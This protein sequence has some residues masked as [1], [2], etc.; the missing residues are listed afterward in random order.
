[1]LPRFSKESDRSGFSAVKKAEKNRAQWP[2]EL[3]R[4]V[5]RLGDVK[6]EPEGSGKAY[7]GESKLNAIFFC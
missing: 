5:S 7:K 3:N 1:M 6:V 4:E 2:G